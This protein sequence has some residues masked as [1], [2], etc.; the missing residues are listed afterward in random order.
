VTTELVNKIIK[1]HL[2]PFYYICAYCLY[3]PTIEIR[4]ASLTSCIY[5]EHQLNYNCL[6]RFDAAPQAVI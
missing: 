2:R 4:I 1:T 6:A 3:V 5:V